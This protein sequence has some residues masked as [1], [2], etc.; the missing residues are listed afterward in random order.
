M[1]PLYTEQLFERLEQILLFSRFFFFKLQIVQDF[2]NNEVFV[3][4]YIDT[5][6]QLN[7]YVKGRKI[8]IILLQK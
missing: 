1:F 4:N 8:E 3:I 6:Y 7:H 5:S 2:S